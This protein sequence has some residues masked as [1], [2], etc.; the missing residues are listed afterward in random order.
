MNLGD[1][2]LQR[3]ISFDDSI[4]TLSLYASHSLSSHDGGDHARIAIRNQLR[5][6]M[7]TW[8]Q[9]DPAVAKHLSDRVNRSENLIDELLSP[10]T[11]GRG[12]ALF[13]GVESGNNEFVTAGIP[14]AERAVFGHHPLVRPLVAALD[15]GRPAGL[16][17]V[18]RTAVRIMQW[19]LGSVTDVERIEFEL[20]DEQVS[21]EKKGPAPANSQSFHRGASNRERFG[22]HV[23][24][25]FARFLKDAM[26]RV[27]ELATG[28]HWDRI[29]IAGGPKWRDPA[30]G[31]VAGVDAQ[32]VVA[33]TQWNDDS[34]EVVAASVWPALRAL[35]LDREQDLLSTV[36]DRARSGGAAVTGLRNVCD[37]LN[38]GRVD[39]LLFDSDVVADGYV[40]DQGTLHPTVG[41]TLAEAEDV[42]FR[43]SSLF[44]ERLVIAA[45]TRGGTAVPVTPGT[46]TALA[47]ADGVAAMLRW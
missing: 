37:A 11:S 42:S 14:F 9:R 36:F 22:D 27:G 6:L 46:S 3:L 32:V 28:H 43:R 10:A 21:R 39:Q 13:V 47:E 8:A 31:F 40:S 19:R 5:D 29:V 7:E 26:A 38:E 24:E 34:V 44:M 4:G 16:V 41:G 45:I 18:S 35:H 33:D 17:D 2:T 20:F 15:E 1:D 12:R 25:Q 23:D 30:K